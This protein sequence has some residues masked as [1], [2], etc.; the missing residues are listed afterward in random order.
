LSPRAGSTDVPLNAKIVFYSWQ[1]LITLVERDSN[2]GVPI[3]IDP[4]QGVQLVW[5]V[6][7]HDFL[8]P[9]TTYEMRTMPGGGGES[10]A[11][12]TGTSMD[13]EAPTYG[14][15]TF[16]SAHIIDGGN[17]CRH[18][19][20]P[21]EG[22]IRRLRFDFPP[23]PADTS[24]LL[25]ETRVPDATAVATIPISRLFNS[26]DWSRFHTSGSCSLGRSSF[27]Q[28][29]PICARIVAVDMAGHRSEPSPE[30]CTRVSAC[31]P[32]TRATGCMWSPDCLALDGGPTGT[33][34]AGTADA[35]W[36]DTPPVLRE[37]GASCDCS[38]TSHASPCV[39]IGSLLP[40]LAAAAALVR[41]RRRCA[42][43]PRELPP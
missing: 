40:A 42:K 43:A 22:P 20:L 35:D 27:E 10:A 26:P 25:L 5:L 7:P 8:K 6:R 34:D 21:A 3:S 36:P 11:F 14:G 30:I 28:D 13:D 12:T 32:P 41:R 19:C 1:S 18:S 24:L 9:N 37:S 15:I 29:E 23:P 4:F 33:N 2:L 39:S 17:E 16:F 38:L 31:A